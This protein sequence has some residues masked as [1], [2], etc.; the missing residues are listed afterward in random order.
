MQFTLLLQLKILR[1]LKHANPTKEA[2]SHHRQFQ[3]NTF[4]LGAARIQCTYNKTKYYNTGSGRG[5][6]SWLPRATNQLTTGQRRPIPSERS[7]RIRAFPGRSKQS[8]QN[9]RRSGLPLGVDNCRLGHG[10]RRRLALRAGRAQLRVGR[11][12]WR[13]RRLRLGLAGR[14]WRFSGRR[15]ALEALFGR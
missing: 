5:A 2:K 10:R 11:L 4:L 13:F 1:I 14:R 15:R 3:F 12:L 9:D 6:S 8:P 7:H